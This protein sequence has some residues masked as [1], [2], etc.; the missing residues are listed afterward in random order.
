MNSAFLY[1]RD[2][3]VVV[4]FFIVCVI[5]AVFNSI[6]LKISQELADY[7]MRKTFVI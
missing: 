2:D 5:D 7:I 3:P 1:Y 4:I 6:S